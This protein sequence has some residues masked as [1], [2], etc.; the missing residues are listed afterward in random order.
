MDQQSSYRVSDM[1][2]DFGASPIVFSLNGQRVVGAGCKNG[3]FV[4][5]DADTMS[6][7]NQRQIL[8]YY[9]KSD[10]DS[11]DNNCQIPT[12]DPHGPDTPTNPNPLVSNAESNTTSAENYSGTYS[13]AA[14]DNPANCQQVFIGVGGNNY[15]YLAPGI[16]Y[17]TTPFMRAMDGTTLK[18][19]WP[20][21]VLDVKDVITG[22]DRKLARYPLANVTMVHNDET[23]GMYTTPGEAGLS[24]PALVNDV[25]F[26][27]TSKV[28]LYA[29]NKADGKLLFSD[30]IGSQTDGFNGGYGYC[31]GPAIAGDYVVVGGLIY[32]SDGGLLKIYRLEKGASS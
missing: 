19:S 8:P 21:E 29:F 9:L 6:Y 11:V 31:M 25:V 5:V 18:D 23:V 20:T 30:R 22:Q 17:T 26:C 32:G 28:A 3:T 16:D 12:V 15:H 24:S 7:V 13:T 4:I 2:V 27:S 14:I 1:D 10:E